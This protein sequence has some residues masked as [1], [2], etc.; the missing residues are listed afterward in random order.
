MEPTATQI[1][2][3]SENLVASQMILYSS[4]RLSPFRAVADDG[5]IDLLIYDKVSG[6]AV[7]VQVKSR[8][9]T[10]K[11]NKSPVAHF[12]VRLATFNESDACYLIPLVVEFPEM[13]IVRAWLIPMAQ[14][15]GLARNDG[16]NLII[17]PSVSLASKDKFSPFRCAGSAELTERILTL[18]EP[19]MG[20]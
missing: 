7:P 4:G 17:R 8:T 2:A 14:L 12:N 6:R 20:V 5:G 11:D 19:T 15:P 1:G 10:L 18:F 13:R 3:I 16:T 9:K